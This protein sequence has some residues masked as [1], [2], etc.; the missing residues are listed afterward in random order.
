M[1]W[2][3]TLLLMVVQALIIFAAFW[4]FSRQP[5]YTYIENWGVIEC[6]QDL[7]SSGGVSICYPPMPKPTTDEIPR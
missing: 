4:L 2:W 5:A 6:R 7:T 3:Q 1:T